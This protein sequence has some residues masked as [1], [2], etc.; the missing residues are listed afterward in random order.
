MK[1]GFVKYNLELKAKQM[2]YIYALFR[3]NEIKKTFTTFS[4]EVDKIEGN[5]SDVCCML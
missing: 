5:K 1:I 4:E 3:P 2:L